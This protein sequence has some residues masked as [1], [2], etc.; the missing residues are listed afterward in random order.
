VLLNPILADLFWDSFQLQKKEKEIQDL[1]NQVS[2]P[3]S[4]LKAALQGL[5]RKSSILSQLSDGGI[6]TTVSIVV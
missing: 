1:K 5:S 2:G 3:A 4:G 6:K